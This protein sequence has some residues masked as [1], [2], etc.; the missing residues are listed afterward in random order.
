MNI[1]YV[2]V[3]DPT[4]PN[5]VVYDYAI[6]YRSGEDDQQ[7]EEWKRHQIQYLGMLLF[8]CSTRNN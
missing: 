7:I 6:G 2:N 8:I 3:C 1:K 5:E 4:G